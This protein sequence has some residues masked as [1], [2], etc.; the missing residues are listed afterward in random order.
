LS[1]KEEFLNNDV[2]H[3]GGHIVGYQL[4]PKLHGLDL[5]AP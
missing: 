3:I 2:L 5:I 1:R 4:K